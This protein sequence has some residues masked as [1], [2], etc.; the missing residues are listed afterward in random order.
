M[1][2]ILTVA[3]R[4]S[5]RSEDS[6]CP[7]FHFLSSISTIPLP[8]TPYLHVLLARLASLQFLT[9]STKA[10]MALVQEDAA[11]ARWTLIYS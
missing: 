5:A 6:L 11:V 10:A 1:V 7:N 4:V 2:L 3:W 8:S 9:F